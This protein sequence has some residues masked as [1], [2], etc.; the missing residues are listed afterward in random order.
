MQESSH[1]FLFWSFKV[2]LIFKFNV[3]HW[4]FRI[5]Q[6]QTVVIIN[7]AFYSNKSM[8]SANRAILKKLKSYK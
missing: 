5:L 6:Y 4:T 8:F 1:N 7:N 3:L 2:F